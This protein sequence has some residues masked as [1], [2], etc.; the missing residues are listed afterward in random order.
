VKKFKKIVS[1][2]Q[3]GISEFIRK[4]L[5]DLCEQ[6]VFYED[7]PKSEDEIIRRMADADGML[8]SWKTPITPYILKALPK[9]K[10]IGMCCSLFDEASSNVNIRQAKEQGIEV[11]GVKDYGDEGVVEFII[12]QLI[13]LFKNQGPVK[14]KDEPIELG[15][16]KL[17]II[18]LGTLGTMVAKAAKA[19]NMDVY[20]HN[21]SEKDSEF[22]YLSMDD[23][24][25]T[26]DIITTHLPRNTKVIS[27]EFFKHM[28]AYSVLINTGLS[29]S[30]DE[31]AFLEWIVKPNR[32]AI[33]DQV[34]LRDDLKEVY[35]KYPNI[36]FSNHVTGFTWNARK[37]LSEKALM[38]IKDYLEQTGA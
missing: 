24:S 34:A 30:Y 2:D 35:S 21:R 13:Q 10:Y 6:V 1:V 9:L 32:Y 23:L 37:R 18:G 7:Q 28:N 17:G 19:F 15:G 27:E 38:N 26:C 22:Q 20:Y 25:K 4:D 11:V 29:P 14:Y 36:Y 33:F 8:V 16:I 5:E 31:V 3:T 12:S